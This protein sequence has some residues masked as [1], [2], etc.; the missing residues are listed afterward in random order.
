MFGNV[1]TT[2]NNKEDENDYIVRLS[3]AMVKNRPKEAWLGNGHQTNFIWCL[4][5]IACSHFVRISLSFFK[6]FFFF[7]VSFIKYILFI[8]LHIRVH[9]HN[10]RV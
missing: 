7:W 9:V 4:H 5:K 2:T 10:N 6:T 8:F 3:I 1:Y